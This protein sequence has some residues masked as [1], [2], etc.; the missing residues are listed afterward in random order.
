[1]AEKPV[2]KENKKGGVDAG[3]KGVA[4]GAK[5][6]AA[7]AK[8]V[9][10]GVNV[11]KIPANSPKPKLAFKCK[12][13]TNPPVF[14][15]QPHQERVTEEFIRTAKKGLLFYHALGSGK[16]CSSYLAID[17]YLKKYANE[18]DPTKQQKEVVVLTPASLVSSHKQ[19]YCDF[20]GTDPVSFHEKFTYYSYNAYR[21]ILKKLDFGSLDNKIILVDEVQQILNGRENGSVI[22]T[23]IYRKLS[24]AKNSKFIFLSGTPCYTPYQAELLLALLNGQSPMD[25]DKFMKKIEQVPTFLPDRCK[26]LI[27]YVPI[28]DKSLYPARLP[29]VTEYIEMSAFQFSKYMEVRQ[30]EIAMHMTNKEAL[31]K[32]KNQNFNKYKE[33]RN[34]EFIR[35]TNLLSRLICNIAYPDEIDATERKTDVNKDLVAK[36]ISKD[37]TL[38][39][40]TNL[41]NK[42]SPKM[43]KV[44]HRVLTLP[45]K[46]MIYSSLTKSSGLY[47]MASFLR[48]CGI[49]PILFTGDISTDK[50]RI[51]NINKFNAV[52]NKT[53]KIHK[54]ILVSGAGAMGISLFGIRH[55]HIFEAG[56]NEFIVFQAEG[57]A[58]RTM[59][60]HQLP[61]EERNVQVYRYFSSFNPSMLA[62]W[63]KTNPS[64]KETETSEVMLYKKAK[65]RMKKT[66]KILEIFRNNAFDCTES[67]NS[68]INQLCG[69]KVSLTSS[70]QSQDDVEFNIDGLVEDWQD[71]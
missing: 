41:R 45:G 5:G 13:R 2:V 55:L 42:Y 21:N 33:M 1:M 32:L 66:E 54:A 40:L 64:W 57:R 46:H 3:A 10:A 14:K 9:D 39:E 12:P 69:K 22:A 29:D 48:Y 26:G 37:Q 6:V 36:W 61:P 35:N 50:Q 44:L 7:G 19:Q 16:T 49:Q 59:S 11:I 23:E 68:A 20:C 18:G 30:K 65:E 24:H 4:A 62:Q 47:L 53:G 63:K 60:H 70:D 38:D 71:E 25:E 31:D 52:E 43:A 8:G 15:A 28:P 67:Y 58:F 51:E 56:L 27:S 34:R 17:Q